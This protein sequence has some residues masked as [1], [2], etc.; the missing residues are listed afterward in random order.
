MIT[1]KD[2]GELELLSALLSRLN[3]ATTLIDDEDRE[4]IGM[5]LLL[6]EGDRTQSVSREAIFK[7]LGREWKQY[8]EQL[9]TI[10]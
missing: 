7:A 2:E 1:P 9:S 5:G 3:I 6:Q 4:D 10:H 8:D